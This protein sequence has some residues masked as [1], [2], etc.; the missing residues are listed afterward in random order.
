[1][2]EVQILPPPARLPIEVIV[3]HY[4]AVQLETAL[5]VAPLLRL[6]DGSL[7]IHVP[8]ILEC[9]G[10]IGEDLLCE[11]LLQGI[12]TQVGERILS[13]QIVQELPL[14]FVVGIGLRYVKDVSLVA[15]WH[16]VLGV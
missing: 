8:K 12:R 6:A 9:H 3:A 1:M 4:A 11:I 13:G 15:D 7:F 2:H 14:R 16:H 5:S 10:F